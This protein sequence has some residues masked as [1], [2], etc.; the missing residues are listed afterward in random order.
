MR[1]LKR[2]LRNDDK[3]VRFFQVEDTVARKPGKYRQLFFKLNYHPFP[4]T[5]LAELNNV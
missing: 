4:T 5:C 1:S 2:N 3:H